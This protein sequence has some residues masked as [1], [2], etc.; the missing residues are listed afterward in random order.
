M[1]VREHAPV[2]LGHGGVTVWGHSG[3]T[4]HECTPVVLGHSG[5]AVCECALVVW[6]ALSGLGFV[7]IVWG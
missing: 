2:V 6:G 3:V 7:V 5:V 4:V 1:A